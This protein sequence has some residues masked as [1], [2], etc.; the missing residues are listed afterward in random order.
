MK[1]NFLLLAIVCSI[2]CF[3]I[4][5]FPFVKENAEWQVNFIDYPYDLMPVNAMTPQTYTLHGDTV[6]DNLTYKKLCMK[7]GLADQPVYLYY[8]AIREQNKQV[9]YIGQGYYSYSQQADRDRI[10]R[11][12]DCLF[13]ENNVS[14]EILLYDF[15]VKV[16]D[17]MHLGYDYSQIIA[18]DSV[19]VGDSYRR[20]LH[21]SYDNDVVIEG[22]G[23][24]KRF[25]LSSVTPI[26]TCGGG[27]GFFTEF[28]SYSQD[29]KVLYKAPTSSFSKGYQSVYSHRKA[30]YQ[31][32]TGKIETLKIDSIALLIDSVFFPSKTI[33]LVGN[34]CYTPNGSGWTGKA[35][36][37]NHRWN[38]FF[39][40]DNDTIK[41]KTDAKL[42]ESWTLFRRPDIT[43]VATVT[44][45]D[46]ATVMSVVDSIKTITLKVYDMSMKPLPHR[47]DGAII[48]LSKNYGLTKTLNFHFVPEQ[49]YAS[50]D[51]ETDKLNLVGITHPELGAQNV[52]WFDV[53]DFQEG[54]E[55]HYVDWESHLMGGGNASERKYIIRILKR[56]NFNDSILYTEDVESLLRYK[57]NASVDYVTTYDHSQ[58]VN[59]IYENPEFDYEPGT[60]VFNEDSTAI[61]VNS[62]FGFNGWGYRETYYKENDCWQKPRII[63][64]VCNSHTFAKGRGE[65]FSG[66]GCWSDQ[67]YSE[68]QQVYYKKGTESWGVPLVLTDIE[69]IGDQQVIDVYPNPVMDEFF[70]DVKGISTLCTF[71]LLDAQGRLIQ[72]TLLNVQNNHLNLHG[73]DSGMYF[74]RI[75]SDNKQIKAGKIIKK[76]AL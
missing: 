63:D 50:V 62:S 23:N 19:W 49:K 68:S 9:F 65:V 74:Y 38:Y 20:R 22:I 28:V 60:M 21:L 35:V 58:R 3:S 26:P 29:G 39:N 53:F 41:I 75:M 44:K 31:T 15:N 66:G 40:D 55:F 33:Q 8:G 25:F 10:K 5:Y 16:G 43:I 54:D 46:T 69:D 51:Y 47:L 34:E 2:N 61:Y 52:K 17:L 24:V 30:Y 45:W 64:D 6:I 59:V 73:L 76:E 4:D 18:V 71:E 7:T 36:F 13:S 56:E 37:V 48:A 72:Q 42:N 11:I 12:N 70:V 32:E 1:K 14:Q 67:D 57:E 27:S